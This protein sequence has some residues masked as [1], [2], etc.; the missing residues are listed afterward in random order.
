MCGTALAQP[1]RPTAMERKVV[2]VLFCDLVGFTARSDQADPEDVHARISP[3]HARLRTDIERYGGTVEKFIG[4]AVMAVF[5]APLAHEDDAERAV[6][7]GLTILDGISDLNQE[8]A[9]LDLQVRVGI[10]TGEAMVALQAR[11]ELGEGIVT[12]DVVNTASRLQGAA[13]VNGVAVGEGTYAAT[14][15]VFDYQALDPVMLKGKASP[16]PIFHAKSVLARFGTDLTRKLTTP[17]VGRE[18]ERNLLTGTFERSVRDASV[19]LITVVGEP[20]VGKSRLVAELFSHLEDWPDLVRWRQGRC[21]PYG[22]GITFWALGEI[23][24]AE[25]G[26]LETDALD[27]AASK[28]DAVIP[29]AHP[30][31]PWLRQRLRPL[32][33]LEAPPAAREE[34]FAA[35]RGFLESLAESRPSVFIFEDLHWADD[36]LLAFLEH[37]ADYAEGVPMLL[38]GTARPELFERAPTWAS[39]ARN[40]NR[41]NL[42]PLSEIETASLVSNL[43]EQ[44]ILPADVQSAILQ[45]S[46]GNPLYAEE[47]VR[48]LKDSNILRQQGATWTLDPAAEIFMP[49]GVQ[50]L[51]AARLDTLSP[52]R[53]RLLQDAAVIGKV[54]WSGAVAQMGERDLKDV[55]DALHELSRREFTRPA[56][57]SSMAGQAEYAF[58][59]ALLR[60]VSYAQIPR[61]S[62]AERHMQAAA[63]I[64]Q[65]AAGRVD[66]HAEILAAHF[67]MALEFATA[68]SKGEHTEELQAKA[69]QYLTMAGDRA[70]GIDVETAERHY[71]RA[72]ELAPGDDPQRPGLLARHGEALRQR[73]RFPEAARAYERAIE[74][75][76][77][78]GDVRAMAV[79]M[80]RYDS[81]LRTLGD[82]RNGAVTAEAMAALEPL[83]PS[84]EL[85][86]VLTEQAGVAWVSGES[87]QAIAF[88]D[89]AIALAEDLGLP[90][91]ARALGLR[92]AARAELGDAQGLQDMR[93]ALNVAGA[94]GL[95]REIALLH[96]N[97]AG[98]LSRLEGPRAALDTLR[99]GAAFAERRGIEEFVLAF[100]EA[101]MVALANLGS[102]TEAMTLADDLVPRLEAAEAMLDLFDVRSTQMWIL[103]R[104][105]EYTEAAQLADWVVDQA[106]SANAPAAVT[107]F[108]LVA[109]LRLAMGK[110]A[111]ALALLTELERIPS[112]RME[113]NYASILPDVV[114]TTLVAGDPGLAERLTEGVE[115]I[116][117]LHK[118][119]LATARALLL[120]HHGSHAEALELYVEAAHGW[121]GFEVPW[122]RAQALLGQGRCLLATNRRTEASEPLRQAREIFATLNAAPALGEVDVLLQRAVA[123]S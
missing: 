41:I 103:S 17:L 6:R 115:P 12:G 20:G 90:E 122:E 21:L 63:W 86:Q 119:A 32:V 91:S 108:P 68:A 10:E 31:A 99:Q 42:A 7:A 118:L 72:L 24:K 50:G 37:L 78:Q 19:Q 100:A 84:L 25:A 74:G 11:P 4:D 92:G 93:R 16:V 64:E 61:A 1:A 111:D 113:P 62:R 47:F 46:G 88:A 40:S 73:G 27:T 18:L 22:D 87:R 76:R 8:D 53:K 35:W 56:R 60:D 116:Y 9:G 97:L 49:S 38:V 55:S 59:H 109:A 39:T 54:F 71:A 23:V 83:G 94:V 58:Q 82:A 98:A 28:I 51:I 85:T 34:N 66:D 26:I 13:P 89:R 69:L 112:V 117:P 5:G 110:A 65:I 79:A 95:G 48:L 77:G 14:R 30:D 96:Y 15:D 29:E 101:T 121:L 33:G 52:D 104:R 45:R 75:F 107:A 44:A 3:Y 123:L 120:E 81:V 105:G 36:A 43:L 70:M 114:R 57:A 106:R 2:T 67:V 102:E 80:G